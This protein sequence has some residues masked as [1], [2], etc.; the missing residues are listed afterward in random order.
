MVSLSVFADKPSY[1]GP[2]RAEECH[3]REGIGHVMD[4]IRAGQPIKIAYFGGSITEMDGWR[5]LSREWLQKKYPACKF[6]EV[7]AAIGGTD[8]GLGVF[9]LGRDVLRHRPDL[10]FVEFAENDADLSPEA[11]WSN[12]DGIVRQVWKTDPTIDIVFVYTVDERMM[13]EYGEGLCPRSASSMERIADHYG[14]PSVGFGPRIAAELKAGRLVMSVGDISTAVPK[15]TPRRDQAINAEL[16]KQGKFLFSK[17][18]V[19]PVLSGHRLY[20]ESIKAAWA[21]MEKSQP[22]DH[23]KK[24][25]TPFYDSRLELAKMVPIRQELCKGSWLPLSERTWMQRHLGGQGGQI[26]WA[27]E[28]GDKLS[29]KFRGSECHL[30]D[31]IGPKCGRVWITVDG[32]RSDR[33]CDRFDSY[34][35]YYR[36]ASFDVFKGGD[37]VHTVEIELDKEQPDRTQVLKS[38]PKA[39]VKGENYNGTMFYP[40]QIQ[41]VGDICE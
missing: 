32:K 3:V 41:L 33:P 21:K 37:G 17:D 7:Q 13:K 6:G 36:L 4:K 5:R 22:T 19:H 39:D 15:E 23:T 24:L 16:K 10:I 1:D 2:V 30:Y 26:W 18:G 29:F 12:F 14:I 28:P 11:I 27:R 35:S 25:A 8:S 40:C 38:N 9:R 34:C 20:L 31:V